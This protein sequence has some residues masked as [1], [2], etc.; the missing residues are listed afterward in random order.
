MEER[1]IR[2]PEFRE[3]SLESK[4]AGHQAMIDQ[5]HRMIEENHRQIALG[6]DVVGRTKMIET[7]TNEIKNQEAEMLQLK[8]DAEK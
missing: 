6:D 2:E 3:E 7:L 1:E 5:M 4:L 8:A